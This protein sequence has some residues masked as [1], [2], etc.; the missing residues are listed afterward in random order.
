MDPNPI[1]NTRAFQETR[2]ETLA[3]TNPLFGPRKLKLGSFCS[4]VSNAGTMS[5]MDGVYE[6]NWHTATR[7]AKLADAMEFEAIVPIARWR[8]FGG[9]TDFNGSTFEPLTFAAA[10]GAQT[11]TPAVFATSHVPA[12]HPVMAAKQATTIDHISGGR[13]ALNVV[14]GW[15]RREIELFGSPLLEHDQR[16][17]VAVEWVSLMKTLWTS[18]EPI[19]FDGQYFQVRDALLKPRPI[20][21]YPALMNAS[22]SPVGKDFAARHFDILFASLRD[23]DLASIKAQ[24]QA[25]R[26]RAYAE[27]GRDLKIWVSAYMIIGDTQED[28]R[29]QLDDCL[30]HGDVEALDHM[31]TEMGIT[32]AGRNSPQLAAQRT[33]LM[34]GYAGYQLMGTPAEIVD[35]LRG[36]C[37]AG[38]DGV[39]LNWPAYLSGMERFQA[40]V[41]PLLV[42]A[43]LR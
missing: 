3:E 43:G 32:S 18:D 24:V 9:V 33:H 28:A 1:W 34:V 37:E 6:L 19:D 17:V 5:S 42:Q 25:T 16:F 35:Q 30:A 26:E 29:R 15:N 40:E 10:M 31:T 20:Q 4:N 39:L 38:L 41:Y 12:I 13:F 8:G 22:S 21:P 2:L 27:H 36:L 14:T 7:A 23:R 11:Q